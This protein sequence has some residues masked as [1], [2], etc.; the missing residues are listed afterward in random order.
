[1][2]LPDRIT[3]PEHGVVFTATPAASPLEHDASREAA[4]AMRGFSYQILTS[5]R[6]W[7]RLAGD[8]AL[9]LEGAED[10][11]IVEE[12]DATTIQVRDTSRS[13]NITLRTSG[14]VDAIGHYWDHRTRNRGRRVS[15]R[16]LTT[17]GVRQESGA[18]FGRDRKG[19]EVWQQLK[20]DPDEPSR[21]Q[22]VAQLKNFLLAEARLPPALLEFLR[23]ATDAQVIEDL[24][25]P[26]EW[27]TAAPSSSDLIQSIKNEL[28]L[29]GKGKGINAITSENV[30][31][32]LHAE[33]WS[34]ATKQNDRALDRAGFL[35]LFDQHTRVPVPLETL[36]AMVAGAISHQP[37]AIERTIV[38]AD[39]PP[40]PLRYY[41][42]RAVLDAI[43]AATHHIV[44][45]LCGATGTGKTTAAASYCASSDAHWG[46]VD[47]RGCD[48]QI[49]ATRL[50]L[51]ESQAKR[52]PHP[53]SL[54]LDDLDSSGDPRPYEASIG[55]L[56][57]TQRQRGAALILTT[58]HDLAP[59]L[60]Q[61]LGI[62]AQDVIRM[63]PFDREEI[64]DF[65]AQRGCN[66]EWC[67]ALA[68]IIGL[69]TRGH[70]Q[71]VHARVASLESA[72]FP[73]P[74][75]S[76]LMQTPSDVL[77]A[78]AEARQLVAQLQPPFREMI[79]RLS[80][81]AS[82]MD[83]E[84][85]MAIAAIWPPID[86]PG[87]AV[88]RLV[89]P[90]I[91]IVSRDIFRISPLIT[92]SGQ[93]VNGSAWAR[94]MH[95]SIAQAFLARQ[96][97]TP[98]DVSA[99]LLHALA[100]GQGDLI[101]TLSMGLMRANKEAWRA[102]AD[103]TAWFTLVAVEPGRDFPIQSRG[104]LL[105]VRMMQYRIA[106]SGK[107]HEA[108]RA[109]ITRFDEEFPQS[110]T[111][112]MVCLSRFMFLTDV[113]LMQELKHPVN[114]SVAWSSQYISLAD[115]LADTLAS[116]E[117]HAGLQK[118]RDYA[119]VW[120]WLCGSPTLRVCKPPWT[121]SMASPLITPGECCWRLG[122]MRAWRDRSWIK[123][124]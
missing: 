41:S 116:T 66:T 19:I 34:V 121:R 87:N 58:A 119:L 73:R 91:E 70:P 84:R 8:Q 55:R 113:L 68:G 11:D 18:P 44:V 97:L 77:D 45:A 5:I 14:V 63:P 12:D 81:T 105:L 102:V 71:L 57:A 108:A 79:Y 23:T 6:E 39:P 36:L 32:A 83:R 60:C 7:I 61:T 40:L 72:G 35:R 27:V 94:D 21:T 100:A 29:H 96:S 95:G 42:R 111:D 82:L 90:W 47:L 114:E 31:G 101:A 112:D 13:G 17:S 88:D 1:M 54:V 93:Q 80:L 16:Y 123:C 67:E 26:I 20:T 115:Q 62:Q 117:A 99:V 76:D 104:G 49:A 51:A 53:F 69:T 107:D 30:L 89:G 10:L 85:I 64:S 120:H 110:T 118:R 33:A 75:A 9:F 22:S 65:L 24:V 15:F 98:G 86:E 109:I 103:M 48:A 46:W 92:S 50:S 38:V 25:V 37:V 2:A 59:R 122:A 124:G 4:N 52:S 43:A 56:V 74:R 106:A 78:Q 3:L 28:I